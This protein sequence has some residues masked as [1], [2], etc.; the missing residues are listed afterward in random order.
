MST[1]TQTKT[2]QATDEQKQEYNEYKVECLGNGI[3]PKTFHQWKSQGTFLTPN[4]LKK[5]SGETDT[6]PAVDKGPSKAS[7][8]KDIYIAEAMKGP[9]V[10][11]NVLIRFQIE[12]GL[13]EKGSATYYANLAKAV[14]DGKLVIPTTTS[15]L[16][17]TEFVL[18]ADQTAE[19]Q[20]ELQAA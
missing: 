2:N 4:D 18:D 11:K 20:S 5:I 8:A 9:L 13:T 7:V 14:K 17:P 3:K 12:A 6:K 16:Q 1:Q 15:G 10:R 19:L